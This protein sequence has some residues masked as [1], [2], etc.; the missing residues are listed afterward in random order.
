MLFGEDPLNVS[1]RIQTAIVVI[2]QRHDVHP[3][4]A[5]IARAR[6]VL[7]QRDVLSS[8]RQAEATTSATELLHISRGLEKPRVEPPHTR[9]VSS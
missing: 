3:A 5:P 8:R 2:D 6:R 4:F 1:A 9:P 7:K